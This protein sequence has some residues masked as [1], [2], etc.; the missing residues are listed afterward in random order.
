MKIVH[1]FH[2]R[3]PQLA[4]LHAGCILK[5]QSTRVKKNGPCILGDVT[6]FTKSVNFTFLITVGNLNSA[7]MQMW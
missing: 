4:L 7:K 3:P 6:R 2:K 5:E 1:F